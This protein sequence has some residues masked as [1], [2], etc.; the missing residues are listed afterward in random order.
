MRK[1][2]WFLCLLST[3]LF[4]APPVQH[5]QTEAG[6][7]V[8]FVATPGLPMLD[9]RL[10]WA[11][12]SA[13]DGAQPG[14]AAMTSAL[15]GS[16]TAEKDATAIAAGFEGLG[17]RFASGAERDS[18][19]LHL[20]TLTLPEQQKGAV[21]LLLE[22][23]R[24]PVF[25]DEEV[26]LARSQMLTG[27]RARKQNIDAVARDAFT[28]AVFA[29]HPYGRLAGA[30]DIEALTRSAAEAFYRQYY[31]AA[32]AVIVLVGD[33]SAAQARALAGQLSAVL[34]QG[35][36]AA[37]LPPVAPLQEAR[38]VRIDF[39]SAQTAVLLGQPSLSR[40]D[41]R[42]LPLM[43]ANHGFGG[44]GF[45][46]VLMDEVREQ[47]GLV[48]SIYSYVA[49]MSEAGPFVIGFKTRNDQAQEALALVREKLSDYI[50][51]GPSEAAFQD[52]IDNITGG[53]PMRTDTNIELA[54]ALAAIG[55]YH[56]PADSLDTYPAR[57]RAV[58]RAQ[59]LAAFA[60]VLAPEKM[61]TVI[62]GKDA[63]N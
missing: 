36:K 19:W 39:P 25:R 40:S 60:E 34:P 47:R 63:Q 21:D 46:S 61:V 38:T 42:R 52:S 37:P 24:E 48:Y 3:P 28:R 17:A 30:E 18:A 7:P 13:R 20:R 59:A 9:V 43:L 55:F 62:V 4:A 50:R 35:R 16:G 32:N 8:Y 53:A 6:A 41:P 49:P 58:T 2:F 31:A 29:G 14:V 22:V 56:L 33:I 10:V 45:A 51:T 26:A 5:W 11:A 1:L 44:N 27:L 54:Q 23:L 12:G 57:V 15:L